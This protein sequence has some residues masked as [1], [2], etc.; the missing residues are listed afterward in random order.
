MRPSFSQRKKQL[1]SR[2]MHLNK[3]KIETLES[4][5]ADKEKELVNMT[6]LVSNSYEENG[7]FND[8]KLRYSELKSDFEAEKANYRMKLE[9]EKELYK[10]KIIELE[11]SLTSSETQRTLV[12]N[13]HKNK[14]E[15]LNIIIDQ[16]KEDL[17]SLKSGAGSESSRSNY[18]DEFGSKKEEEIRRLITELKK[19]KSAHLDELEQGK[20][21]SRKQIEEL[22]E[23]FGREK[24]SLEKRILEVKEKHKRAIEEIENVNEEMLL[25]KEQEIEELEQNSKAEIDYFQDFHDNKVHELMNKIAGLEEK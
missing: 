11:D 21:N 1:F 17:V 15:D 9:K 18:I 23:S 16:L 22:K 14:I 5:L 12:E 20:E 19:V 6:N 7:E 4:E 3:E 24:E 25:K 13:D 2:I 8:L 10:N